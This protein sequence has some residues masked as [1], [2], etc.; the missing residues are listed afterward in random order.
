[1]KTSCSHWEGFSP[2]CLSSLSL[3]L[4][5]SLFVVVVVVVVVVRFLGRIVSGL[6]P[7]AFE[8]IGHLKPSEAKPSEAQPIE[9][10]QQGCCLSSIQS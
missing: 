9:G 5:F 4:P 7:A 1:M 3:L 10:Q 6:G 2:P 8:I